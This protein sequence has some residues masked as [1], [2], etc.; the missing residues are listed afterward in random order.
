MS[1]FAART[2]RLRSLR[3]AVALAAAALA[4]VGLSA[5]GGDKTA[6]AAAPTSAAPAAVPSAA[7]VSNSDAA[8]RLAGTRY[9]LGLTDRQATIHAVKGDS[10]QVTARIPLDSCARNTVTISPD[11]KR[12]A[13]V[14]G[15]D[16]DWQSGTLVTSGIDGTRQR[17]LATDVNCLG[18]R[19]LAWKGSDLLMVGKKSGQSVLFD[20]AAGKPVQGDPGEETSRC[21]SAD[22]RWLAAEDDQLKPFVSDGTQSR[23]YSYTP[24][25]E[26]A[27]HW[28]GWQ[29]QS[30][31]MDGRY[32]SVGWTGTDPSRRDDSF[33]VVDT[34]SSNVVDLPVQGLIRSIT[35]TIDDKVIVK[36]A[37]GITVLDGSLKPLGTVAESTAVRNMKLL[38]YVP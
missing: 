12:L 32:V 34:I 31:S 19:A 9:Y 38:A 1:I 29:A 13:W 24:P 36:Q 8:T 20:V 18:P 37:N 5:C 26:E 35:F 22:G 28:D 23:Q 10:D 2:A 14:R 11:G 3:Q 21:W 16:G 6:P 33:A 30:V 4:T 25:K 7:P 17:T 27:A 15:A